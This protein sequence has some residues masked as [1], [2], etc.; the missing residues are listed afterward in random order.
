M[1]GGGMGGPF[2]GFG[3]GSNDP[4]KDAMPPGL[5][6][7]EEM[8]FSVGRITQMLEMNFQ[9]EIF[10]LLFPP[11]PPEREVRHVRETFALLCC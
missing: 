8:L 2:G 7:L 6:H 1:Y 3:M 9:V 4:Y 10:T 5:R 11:P